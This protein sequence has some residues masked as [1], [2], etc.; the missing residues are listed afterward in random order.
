VG[1]DDVRRRHRSAISH[2]EGRVRVSDGVVDQRRSGIDEAGDMEMM[3][4][5]KLFSIVMR[6][7]SRV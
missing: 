2:A 4:V 5:G 3:V 6:E 1:A 7:A